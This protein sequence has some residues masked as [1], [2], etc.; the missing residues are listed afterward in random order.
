MIPNWS[1]QIS[2]MLPDINQFQVATLPDGV[3]AKVTMFLAG[4][5]RM[6]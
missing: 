2:A 3:H 1:L 5:S 6:L 4:F